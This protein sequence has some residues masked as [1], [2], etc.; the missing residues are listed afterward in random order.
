V[1]RKGYTLIELVATSALL[2]LVIVPS[3]ELT[4]ES[5]DLGNRLETRATMTSL[6]IGKLEEHLALGAIDLSETTSSGSFAS[7]GHSQLR[8]TVVRSQD[9]ADGGITDRLMA[10]SATVWDDTNGNLSLDSD[11]PSITFASKIAKTWTYTSEASGA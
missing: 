1:R 11:E 7:I 3:L 5:L 2:A 4:R 6:C 8:Y 10:V 9:A